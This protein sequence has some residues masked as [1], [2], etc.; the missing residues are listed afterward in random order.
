MP[1]STL[2]DIKYL[3]GVPGY[4]RCSQFARQFRLHSA[5]YALLRDEATDQVNPVF[6]HRELAARADRP[7][8]PCIPPANPTAAA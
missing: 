1:T 3:E 8:P 7:S 6:A 4:G 5:N 2:Q